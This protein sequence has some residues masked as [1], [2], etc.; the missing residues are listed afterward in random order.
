[1]ADRVLDAFDDGVACRA[2]LADPS[3]RVVDLDAGVLNEG[4]I[5]IRCWPVSRYTSGQ[6]DPALRLT[7]IAVIVGG[8]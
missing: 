8:R 6:I 3:A 7:R 5:V 1:M 4:E 2:R